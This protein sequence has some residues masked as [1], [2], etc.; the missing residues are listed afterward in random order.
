[1]STLQNLPSYFSICTTRVL[2]PTSN[3]KDHAPLKDSSQKPTN[4]Q[5]CLVEYAATV[6]RH[7]LHIFP[8]ERK[9]PLAPLLRLKRVRF[10][11]LPAQH[12]TATPLSYFLATSNCKHRQLP[13]RNPIQTKSPSMEII[14]DF[15][16]LLQDKL[17]HRNWR[18]PIIQY[19]RT[20]RPLR[21]LPT[22]DVEKTY[23]HLRTVSNTS[24][25]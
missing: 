18:L 5:K 9:H 25:C 10:K 12:A 17:E 1:M 11:S 16:S 21:H 6:F 22:Y 3:C 7:R 20:N 13:S 23:L 8:R 14:G 2:P 19:S 4:N 15:S 24:Y